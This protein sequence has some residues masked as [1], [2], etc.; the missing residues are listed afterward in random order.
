MW[1]HPS[2]ETVASS[3]VESRDDR[4]STQPKKR[5]VAVQFLPYGSPEYAYAGSQRRSGR[6]RRLRGSDV[7][8][9]GPERRGRERRVRA[10][11]PGRRD[12]V[13]AYP[14]RWMAPMILASIVSAGLRMLKPPA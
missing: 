11:P 4:P 14:E 1:D 9:K 12:V 10:V 3:A 7:F 6:D 2:R 13:S 8:Y 5:V